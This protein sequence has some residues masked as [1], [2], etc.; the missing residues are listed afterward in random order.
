M[1]TVGGVK[2]FSKFTMAKLYLR[3]TLSNIC[4]IIVHRLS[5]ERDCVE[6]LVYEDILFD[7]ASAQTKQVQ[8]N[9]GDTLQKTFSLSCI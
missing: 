6:K 7:F 4:C 9:N 2:S 1:S 3:C 5:I 8:F